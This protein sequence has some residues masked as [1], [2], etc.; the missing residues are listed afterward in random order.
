[1]SKLLLIF[2]ACL[3]VP[4]SLGQLEVQKCKKGSVPTKLVIEGCS[5]APCTIVNGQNLKFSAEFINLKTVYT[6]CRTLLNT[7]N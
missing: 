2:V 5:K 7:T 1:M 4:N 3:T 6:N